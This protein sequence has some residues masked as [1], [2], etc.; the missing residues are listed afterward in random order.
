[1]CIR[2]R[3]RIEEI[4]PTERQAERTSDLE[5][6][7]GIQ[8]HLDEQRFEYGEGAKVRRDFDLYSREGQMSKRRLLDYYGLVELD[9]SS[10]AERFFNGLKRRKK[11]S[12]FCAMDYKR[13][14][15]AVSVLSRGSATERLDFIFRF[16]DIDGDGFID[17][18]EMSAVLTGFLETMLAVEFESGDM[19]A[20]R[21][22]ILD[23]HEKT[24]EVAIEEIVDDIYTKYQSKPGILYFDDWANWYANQ[25]G[26]MD[27]ITGR[28]DPFEDIDTG[29]NLR[30]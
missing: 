17:R 29:N 10:F 9:K 1:M 20:L 6:A 28:I 2:D 14:L 24:I 18:D 27:I 16:F 13:F 7:G 30:Y 26:M 5:R 11:R 19:N 21:G 23:A 15:R 8:T 3:D 25:E 22:K 4:D 12:Q